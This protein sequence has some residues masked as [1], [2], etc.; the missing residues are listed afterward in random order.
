MYLW[1]IAH[2]RG[3]GYVDGNKSGLNEYLPAARSLLASMSANGFSSSAVI[4]VDPNGDILGGAHRTACALA[5]DLDVT[6]ETLPKF[7][8][9]P[10]WDAAWFRQ[11]GMPDEIVNELLTD[12]RNLVAK[13][14]E[15]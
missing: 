7:A 6:C 5:L 1:H 8:W 3:S 13:H 10:A 9:A 15:A 2:R 14:G 12:F 4:P 11:H